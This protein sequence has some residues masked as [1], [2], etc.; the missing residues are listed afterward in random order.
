MSPSLYPLLVDL[1]MGAALLLGLRH[2]AHRF[3]YHLHMAQLIGYKPDELLRW[4]RD[5]FSLRIVT[6]EHLFFGLIL[7]ALVVLLSPGLTHTSAGILLSLFVFFWF[8]SV[9]RHRGD[10]EKKPLVMTARA[11]RLALT[12]AVPTLL[13]LLTGITLATL[14]TLPGLPFHLRDTGIPL[15]VA[16]PYFLFFV[17]LL[18][19]LLVPFWI[20]A[21]TVVNLPFERRIQQGFKDQA[22][23][24]LASI[25]GLKVVALTGSFGKTSTKFML[26]ALLS[27]RFQVCTT[28]GSFNTPMGI[29]RVINDMLHRDHQVLLLEMGARRPGDLDEL[30]DI[31]QPDISLITAVGPA[32]LDTL[33]SLDGIEREKS[34]LA[35]RVK[36][37]GVLVLNADDPRVDR[38]GELRDDVYVLRTGLNTPDEARMVATARNIRLTPEGYRF[39]L[40]LRTDPGP[41]TAHGEQGEQREAERTESVRLSLLGEHNLRN[42]LMA[43]AAAASLGLRPGTIAAGARRIKP[44]AHRLEPKTRNGRTI[45]DDAFNSNPEGAR[46]ALEALRDM[47]GGRKVIVT[48]GMVE[49]GKEQDRYNREFGQRIAKARLDQILLVGP[50]QTR[51]I[52]EGIRGEDPDAPVRVVRSLGEAEQW[53]ADNTTAGD[54]I[55]YENDLPDT[56]NE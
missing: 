50:E 53:L 33:G 55:L 36:P 1:L 6:R 35:R 13:T 47:E 46:A 39:D 52:L 54:V 42:F 44:V 37:G 48:P 4:Q 27:E 2:T 25:P 20:L 45:L 32:H 56:Y 49:L 24:R 8:G 5:R 9:A 19:D 38:M 29:C 41:A 17:L 43:A 51:P 22:A 26:E 10:A 23:R 7:T 21:A 3:R 40:V 14:R 28:P 12:A 18:T 31:A 11:R 15:L 30:C 16:D 34:T